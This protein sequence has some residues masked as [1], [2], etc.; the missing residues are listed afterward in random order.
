MSLGGQVRSSMRP[1]PFFESTSLCG[2]IIFSPWILPEYAVA[3]YTATYGM[4]AGRFVYLVVCMGEMGGRVN[5]K[6]RFR[7]YSH[8]CHQAVARSEDPSQII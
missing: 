2:Y 4:W 6:V 8:K 1:P 3:S 7:A 5:E